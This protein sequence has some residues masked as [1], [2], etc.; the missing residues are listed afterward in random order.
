MT[1]KVLKVNEKI[2]QAAFDKYQ[3]MLTDGVVRRPVKGLRY[4]RVVLMTDADVD[5]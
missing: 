1:I 2:E 5:G 3:T 4:G